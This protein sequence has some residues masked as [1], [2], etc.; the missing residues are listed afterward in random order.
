MEIMADNRSGTVLPS[1]VMTVGNDDTLP[2]F[3]DDELWKRGVAI[4]FKVNKTNINPADSGYRSVIK[5]MTKLPAGYNF[6]RLLLLRGSASPEGPA[7]NNRWLAHHRAWALVDSLKRYVTI[8]VDAVEER[9]VNEDYPGL[10]RMLE[11]SS[12]PYKKEVE[13]ILR[14]STDDA[15]AKRRLKALDRGKAWE[16]LLRDYYPSLRATRVVIIVSPKPVPPTAGRIIGR[17]EFELPDIPDSLSV[18]YDMPEL[19]AV[20]KPRRELLAVKTNMLLDGAYVPNYGW[21]PIPNVEIEYYPLRGH[22][23]FGASFDMP[24][25][26]SNAYNDKTE[27]STGENHKFFQARQYQLIA[28]WYAMNGGTQDGFHG[29]YIQPYLNVA[30][31]GIGFKVDKGWMGEGAGGGVGIGYK[32]PLGKLRSEETGF[33]TRASHWHIEFSAQVGAYAYKYDPYQWGCP[34]D[35]ITDGRYYYRYWG[36]PELFHKRNHHKAWFGPTRVGISLSYDLL[37]R[38]RK[39]TERAYGKGGAR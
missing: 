8:P 10:A 33:R 37:Y 16:L 26:Q 14:T 11:G 39:A 36:K 38:S 6:C 12:F 3:S 24:W 35:G 7:D 21:C 23:T 22:W 15:T 5:A 1:F 32:L 34:K 2:S 28:R 25:W 4:R 31:F 17:A 9:Y 19:P 30:I 18:S 27:R 29:F 13:L 20:E